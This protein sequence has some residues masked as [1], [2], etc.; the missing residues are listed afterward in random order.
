MKKLIIATLVVV[1]VLISGIWGYLL[2]FGAPS[3]VG[4]VF[5][6][7]GLGTS[8]DRVFEPSED[9]TESTGGESEIVPPDSKK[10]KLLS[11]R[12]TAGSAI[13]GTGTAQR[14]VRMVEQGTGHIY[15]I[16]PLTNK[17]SRV[18]GTTY[19]GITNAYVSPDGNIVVLVA[20]KA[21]GRT[22]QLVSLV[23]SSS[24]ATLLPNDATEFG[25]SDDSNR[26]F[27][28]RGDSKGS[29]GYAYTIETKQDRV[30]FTV[31]FRSISVLWGDEIIIY[32]R[33]G[34]GYPG[35]AYVVGNNSQLETLSVGGDGLT[36]FRA[37]DTVLVN[38]YDSEGY[39]AFLV[40]ENDSDVP[41]GLIAM[42]EKC[43]AGATATIIWCAESAYKGSDDLPVAWYKGLVSF[44][45]RLTTIDVTRGTQQAALLSKE[46]NRPIDVIDMKASSDGSALV[47]TD[48]N[49]NTLW[50][51][52]T[53]VN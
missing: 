48:K 37:G 20:E 17:E 21:V 52:D 14:V 18:S 35:F 4:D 9:Q 40:R 29:V 38:R 26:L 25:F 16:D 3:S 34:E 22:V 31:P 23:S 39:Q 44:T 43:A 32:N 15:D 5:A 36:V 27:Y 13:I 7:L 47:F 6:D 11:L 19:A 2:F 45:D 8:E 49:S 28:V 1:L 30:L 41:L 53:T 51:F 24:E 42:P 46:A 50:Y 12:T 10:L 33:P